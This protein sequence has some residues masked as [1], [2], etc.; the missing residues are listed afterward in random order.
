MRERAGLAFELELWQ[1]GYRAIAGIDE[2]GRGALAGPVVA[3]AVILPADPLAVEPLLGRVDDSKML[4]AK[5]REA[6]YGE[7]VGARACGRGGA[8]RGVRHRRLGHCP[9]DPAGDG[10]R[11]RGAALPRPTSSCSTSSRCPSRPAPSA[12]SRTATRCRSPS[13][14]HRWWRK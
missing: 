11:A 3:A 1:A 2:V 7:I 9:R 4:T 8:V 14:P 13:R 10:V 12:A 5:Q 6:L